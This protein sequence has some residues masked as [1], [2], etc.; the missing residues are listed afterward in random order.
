MSAAAE[1]DT[2][3][4]ALRRLVRG[5]LMP[6][7]VGTTVP[8]WIVREYAAG[9][10]S[11]CLY[12]ANLADAEQFSRLCSDLR[13]AGPDL[14][15]AIDEEGG[16]VTRLHY[17]TGSPQPGN[18]ILGRLDDEEI[19]RESG[20]SIGRELAAYGINL[21]LAP[22]VDVNSAD[23]NP[24]IGT[25]S[26][27]ADAALVG[28]HSAAWVAGLQSVGVAGCAKHFPGH[29]DTVTDSHLALP[30]VD[31]PAQVLESRELVPFRAAVAAGVACVMTSHIVVSAIDPDR[32]ATFSPVL[33]GAVLRGRLGFEGVVVSDALDM[34]GASA[35][36]RIPEA[37]VRA[38]GAGC[39]LLCLGSVTSEET[40]LAVVDALVEAVGAGRLDRARLE[41][42]ARR[43]ASLAAAY[44]AT[45]A[46]A[47]SAR[48]VGAGTLLSEVAVGD[49]F[50]LSDEARAWLAADGPASIVQVGSVTNVAV[51]Q[52]AWGPAAAGLTV[53]E[54]DVPP[55]ARVAVAGR[56][57]APDHPAWACAERLRDAGHE[58][59]V[60]ECG[61]PR[62]G[63]D[64]AT[65]GGSL[66]AGAALGRLLQV[67]AR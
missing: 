4:E 33:L 1:T 17:L 24:V 63:A 31:A 41:D 61:W 53:A 48:T 50:L 39:D 16:D 46:T 8:D 67:G 42:A 56:G 60:V 27:G 44:P 49:G 45:V 32:P 11:V 55:G 65:Y 22:V 10:A 7:F 43:V 13:G 52:V 30:R 66:A 2:T 34:A 3:T 58:T 29:G 57:L 51:G 20:V 15:L 40:H 19:T 28:R 62:G 37:A 25:R 12:G 35:E 6:G 14:V 9:L 26:F 47:Q 36:T 38:L 21:D 23:E 54:E 64:I 5:T 59:I 18:A